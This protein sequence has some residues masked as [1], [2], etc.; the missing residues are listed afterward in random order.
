MSVGNQLLMF[1]RSVE[2]SSPW[3][4]IFELQT[5]GDEGTVFIKMS[6][7]DYPATQN[8]IPGEWNREPTALCKCQNSQDIK[9]DKNI[10][11]ITGCIC[12]LVMSY[13]AGNVV[14][15]II[16]KDRREQL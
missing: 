7:T 14:V 15:I 9:S 4:Q 2:P 3:I 1:K 11:L 10:L 12:L 6:G 16:A 5:H 8:H 13:E